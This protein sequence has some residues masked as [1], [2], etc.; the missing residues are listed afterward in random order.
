M[1]GMDDNLLKFKENRDLDVITIVSMHEITQSTHVKLLETVAGDG[2]S[3]WEAFSLHCSRRSSS[4][5][6]TDIDLLVSFRFSVSFL[7]C[8]YNHI[9]C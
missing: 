8:S 4:L 5:C 3:C 2:D 9:T 1:P 7:C 6:C